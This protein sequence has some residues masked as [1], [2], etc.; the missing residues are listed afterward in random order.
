M[1]RAADRLLPGSEPP[2]GPGAAPSRVVT[3]VRSPGLPPAHG[4]AAQ[5]ARMLSQSGRCPGC[6]RT[7][8][9]PC[10]TLGGTRSAA[11]ASCTVLAGRGG[12]GR[13][14][15]ASCCSTDVSSALVLPRTSIF[16]V[17]VRSID[18]MAVL[19]RRVR[20]KAA[21][22]H[23]AD[24]GDAEEDR[25]TERALGQEREQSHGKDAL[26]DV[27]DRALRRSRPWHRSPWRPQSAP[28]R[29]PSPG[30]TAP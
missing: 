13:L 28:C 8:G 5:P 6:S 7:P 26:G 22:G 23:Q 12:V 17:P 4:A 3:A 14:K 16:Q 24:P 20:C 18:E 21:E 19:D 25:A 29:S 30:A 11:S 15:A 1:P 9:C 27:E 10:H 2:P